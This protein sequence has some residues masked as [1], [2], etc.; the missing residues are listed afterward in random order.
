MVY[1]RFPYKNVE[2][3]AYITAINILAVEYL[4]KIYDWDEYSRLVKQ[5]YELTEEELHDLFI[6]LDLNKHISCLGAMITQGD[7][8]EQRNN[9]LYFLDH[10]ED[11]WRE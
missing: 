8:D 2:T 9:L 4:V 5:V 10:P 1:P 7:Y 3:A 6:L 11:I